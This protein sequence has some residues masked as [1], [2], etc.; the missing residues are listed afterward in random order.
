MS[1]GLFLL[2]ISAIS[3]GR[4]MLGATLFAALLNFKHIFAYAAPLY[5]V[6]LLRH[7][8]RQ[9]RLLLLRLWHTLALAA[10]RG[11]VSNTCP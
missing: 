2:S 10:T 1:A 6:Y 11:T 3:E 8:C 7:Y 9:V 4:D 5:F